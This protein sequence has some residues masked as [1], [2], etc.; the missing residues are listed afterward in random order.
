[1]K[2][3][4]AL[5]L[6][7]TMVFSTVSFVFAE[8]EAVVSDEGTALA[9]LGMLEGDGGGYTAEYEA[10]E[11]TRLTAAAALLKLK[12]L[13]EEAIEYDGEDNFPDV[14]EY[15]WEGGRNLMAYLKANPSLGFAGDAEGNFNP[16]ANI[17]E[18]SY[19][20]VLLET[21]GYK[22]TT[23]DVVGDFAWEDTLAFAE[24]VGL[25]PAN[26]EVF[27]IADLAK[28]T[29]ATLKN[30]TKDG[31]VYLDTLIEAGI[32][33]EEK[34]VAAGF[35]EE[36]PELVEVEVK[37][38]KAVGN[39]AVE[40]E[41]KAAID[42]AAEN[43]D[44]YSIDGLD[45]L[46]ASIARKKVVRLDTA[47]QKS[48]KVY[49]LVV[50]EKTFQF[51]GVAKV[52]G[53]PEIDGKPVSEDVDE[54]VIKF[55]KKI[56]LE[57]GS[58]VDTYNIAGVEIVKAEVKEDKVTLTTEGLENKKDYTVKVKNIKSVDG[59]VKKA[60][61]KSFR[62]KFDFTAPSIKGEI[63]RE[64]FQRIVV[65]F[66][67]KVTQESAEDLENYAIKLNKT[68]GEELEILEITWDDDDEDN[69]TIVTEAMEKNKEYKITIENIA[70]QRK[71][72]NVMT[73][74]ASKTFKG[75]AEDKEGPKV[76]NI[77]V[78]SPERILV[79]YSDAS[80]IDAD[81][82][83]DLNNYELKDLD[84]YDIEK[85]RD[86]L[87]EFKAIL[88]VEEMETD[89]GYELKIND[90]L[91]EFGNEMKN[92]YKKT[93]RA[94]ASEFA[95]AR[96]VKSGAD[97]PVAT[98]E[99]TVKLVFTKEVDKSSA[100]NIANYEITKGIGAPTKA[101]LEKDKKT[102]TLTVADL[103]NG[104]TKY[105]VVVD[106]VEDLASNVLYYKED[107]DAKTEIWDNDG[108]ELE[109]IDI[110]DKYTVA[111]SFD[112]K[113]KV[114]SG[115][116]L[117]L[118]EW[119]SPNEEWLTNTPVEL[120][121]KDIVEDDMTI[122]FGS[123][124]PLSTNV[125]YSVYKFV[126]TSGDGGITDLIGNV[127]KDVTLGDFEFKGSDKEK[128]GPE[129]E[130]YE[131][132]NGK[133]FEVTMSKN[134]EFK[135]TNPVSVSGLNFI[136]TVDTSDRNVVEF[137]A[138]GAITDGKDYVFTFADLL[139]DCHDTAAVEDTKVN[140]VPKTVLTG[141]Y[142]DD[143]APYIDEV[144]A[145]N[146]TVIKVIFDEEIEVLGGI[147]YKDH[148]KLR[149]YDLDKDI[150]INAAAV[151]GD[152]KNII[153]LT[154]AKALEGRYEYEL[155]FVKGKA[156]KDLV[157]NKLEEKNDAYFYFQGTNLTD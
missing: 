17:N 127:V 38:A 144:V 11:M 102:V 151:T 33:D 121:Y 91:D 80:K 46:G 93:V 152:D 14:A 108:P 39:S 40:V 139:K 31:V 146:R 135:G 50:G 95:S 100:E 133:T 114:D 149:N 76:A 32:V 24:E 150:T 145:K 137:K 103:I 62:T 29:V 111:L 132:I 147:G 128:E 70:D 112:E 73:R 49:K 55:T 34:A 58:D 3:V 153:E 52:S 72:P 37:E 115:L 130:T 60:D 131:Q 26:V 57:T 94:Y 156:I 1:M 15:A 44:N 67:E 126:Y 9:T 118:A 19:Y 109:D 8:E 74:A 155:I 66:T 101:K 5:I 88:N 84:I 4:L 107:L 86:E 53:A 123:S 96:L 28:A 20:K 16:G 82:A 97:K 157:D 36:A 106:G 85:Y 56:D 113:V 18:Q 98:D 64:T 12:G 6:A 47:A 129:M 92:E 41:F 2:K 105:K 119:D 27:T 75:L 35:V 110:L 116:K 78:L 99:N 142:T 141:E 63:E 42:A 143:D 148:F 120:A 23:A 90:I 140:D 81:S 54:V 30:E 48:G 71:T 59:A 117:Q 124:S 125:V 134:V 79:V 10:K 69:V 122:E 65:N 83:L 7:F 154:L 22:Q 89:K 51:T 77:E 61:S 136:I 21:L 43:L 68:D 25:V 104:Y 87:G 13:Y 138:D 45:I